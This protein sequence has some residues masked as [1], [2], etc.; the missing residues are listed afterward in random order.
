MTI[1]ASTDEDIRM[2]VE[3]WLHR[4]YPNYRVI[5]ELPMSSFSGV[6]RA[7]I[8]AVSLDHIVLLEIKSAKDTLSRLAK[9]ARAMNSLTP[10]WFVVLDQR[11][12]DPAAIRHGAKRLDPKVLG[13]KNTYRVWVWPEPDY[14]WNLQRGHGWANPFDL[15]ELLWREELRSIARHRRVP[16]PSRAT[17]HDLKL[18]LCRAL[19]GQ[20]VIQATCAALRA[21]EFSR[22][23]DPVAPA[24]TRTRAANPEQTTHKHRAGID[25]ADTAVERN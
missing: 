23:D 12:V 21:R 17:R 22:A 18:A 11:W 8:A 7:D 5:H 15:L 14:G 16:A 4:F 1:T 3:R 13:R 9:Q 10:D 19:T 6:G 2:D 24:R 25:R 20:T